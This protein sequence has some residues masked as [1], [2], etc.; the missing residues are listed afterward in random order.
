MEKSDGLLFHIKSLLHTLFYL[1]LNPN[2]ILINL[3][4]FHD[5]MLNMKISN[6]KM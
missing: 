6:K 4:L 5:H 1:T 2:Y 3:L